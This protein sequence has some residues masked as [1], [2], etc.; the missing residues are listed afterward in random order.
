MTCQRTGN[1]V[2]GGWFSDPFARP[3][4]WEA[5]LSKSGRMV[6]GRRLGL[7][8]GSEPERVS[9]LLAHC[10]ASDDRCFPVCGRLIKVTQ[11]LLFT[12]LIVE[13]GREVKNIS[14]EMNNK[15]SGS[16]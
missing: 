16:C 1:Q 15:S 12:T 2:L 4:T 8:L 5:K 6:V 13:F 9:S 14:R 10:G 3:K 7:C 11:N